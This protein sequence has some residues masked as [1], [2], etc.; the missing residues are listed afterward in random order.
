MAFS[1]SVIYPV[2][3]WWDLFCDSFQLEH[4][5]FHFT[6]VESFETDGGICNVL[7]RYFKRFHCS[8]ADLKPR[9]TPPSVSKLSTKVKW[10]LECS[11]WDLSQNESHHCITGYI[12]EVENNHHKESGSQFFYYTGYEIFFL[13]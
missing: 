9:K 3:Q 6:F 5:G 11:N 1:T 8:M 4:P 7:K 13:A 10:K 12:E 2:I